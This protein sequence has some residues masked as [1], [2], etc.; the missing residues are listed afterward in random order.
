MT[1]VYTSDLVADYLLSRCKK[2]GRLVSNKKLQ[3]LVYYAQA[4]SL[5]LNK[6][7]LFPE[8]IEAWVHGPAIMGLYLRFKPF[9]FGPIEYSPNEEAFSQLD[10]QTRALL[11]N[12]VKVYGTKDAE[13]LELLSHSEEPWKLAREGL[14]S[15]DSSSREISHK[16]MVEYYRK[17]VR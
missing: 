13:Y 14:L 3:K 12:V 2:A 1:K 8:A 9:G 7:P 15:S 10:R 4:W 17:L 11:D 5:T 16:S 6:K